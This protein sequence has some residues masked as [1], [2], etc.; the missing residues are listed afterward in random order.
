M[1]VLLLFRLV[2]NTVPVKPCP[3]V[4]CLGHSMQLS[5]G[6]K[7]VFQ[8]H[9]GHQDSVT[10]SICCWSELQPRSS[11]IGLDRPELVG[12]SNYRQRR[13]QIAARTSLCRLH[14]LRHT[15][16]LSF[17]QGPWEPWQG[18]AAAHS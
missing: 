1:S 9:K 10:S 13:A 7:A 11:W 18:A 15:P 5:P 14:A 8:K 3:A 12:Q 17:S 4:A 2:Y 16:E 6:D